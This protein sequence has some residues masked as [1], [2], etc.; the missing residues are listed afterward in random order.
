MKTCVK[1]GSLKPLADFYKHPTATGGY[2]G[3]CKECAKQDVRQNRIT[4]KAYYDAYNKLRS[5]SSEYKVA[6][7]LR[8]QRPEYRAWAQA[9]QKQRLQRPEVKAILPK[10]IAA[11]RTKYPLKYKAQAAVGTAVR[12]GKL[13]RQPCFYCGA[14]KVQAHHPDYTRPLDVVWLCQPCHVKEHAKQRSAT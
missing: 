7:K 5:Q 6:H 1:C 3:K 2:Q 9:Y 11:W 14:T 10:Y 12:N 13:Q 8:N 4:N